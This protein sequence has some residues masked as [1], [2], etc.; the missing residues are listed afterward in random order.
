MPRPRVEFNKRFSSENSFK[1]SRFRP[2]DGQI[3]VQILIRLILT[4][5]DVHLIIIWAGVF[6]VRADLFVQQL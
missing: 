3:P 2:G 1:T 5:S 6:G 4:S